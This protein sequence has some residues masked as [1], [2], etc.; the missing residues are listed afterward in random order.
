M[1]VLFLTN[2]YRVQ[3]T[4]GEDQSCQQ[5]VQGLT[6]RGHTTLVLTSMHGTGNVPVE[7]DGVYRSLFLEM[8]IVPW[9]HSIT[10]FTRRKAREQHNLQCFERVLEEFSPDVIFIWGMWNLPRSLAALAEAKYPDRVVYRFATYWP[11]LPSQHELYWRTPGRNWSSKL[12]KKLLCRIA[13]AMLSRENQRP[14]LSFKHAICVSATTRRKLVEAGIP[15]ANARIIHTG[16][17]HRRFLT[18]LQHRQLRDDHQTVNLLY[19]G[20]LVAEK[21]VDTAIQ[22]MKTLIADQAGRKIRLSLAGSG[23]ADYQS[24]LQRLVAQAGLGEY[25]S[26]LGH[27]PPED[28]PRL[29]Q[30]FDV[31]LV[32]SIWEEPFSRMVLEG[33]ISGLVVVATPTGGTI[34][35]LEDGENG[36]LF[37]PGDPED[38]A[39]KITLLV[40][41][42]HLRQKLGNAGRQTVIERF[43]VTRMMDEI[44]NFL[45]EVAYPPSDK[46]ERGPKVIEA[47]HTPPKVSVII[48]TYNH[49]EALRETLQSLAQQTYPSHCFEVIIVDDGSID[50]TQEIAAENFPFLLRYIQQNNQGDAAAR[51]VGA[52]QSQADVLVF[53]DDDI[54]VEPDYLTCLVQAQAV[55]KDRIVAGTWDLWRT[56]TNGQGVSAQILLESGAYYSRGASAEDKHNALNPTILAVEVPF[57]DIHSNNMA[58]R[59]ESYF[60]IGMMQSLEFSGSSMWCDLEFT[61]R[62]YRQ[63]YRFLRS[64]RAIC[65]H[66][67]RWAESLEDFKK[68]MREAAYRSV[69]LFQKHPELIFHVPMFYD[70]TPIKW[71]QDPPRLIA[72]KMARIVA[73]SRPALWSMERIVS[74]L[75]KYHPDSRVLP[76]LYRYVIGGS[77]FQGYRAG[78]GEFGQLSHQG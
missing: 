11:T 59:R 70:K 67:D 4:G 36:L 34:E 32:P 25:V 23:S 66:R 73:S 24:Y 42:P 48:P 20:R 64:T 10:F 71:R 38:L 14:K 54:L 69:R 62:A 65:W 26:F 29:L 16:I 9:R 37:T 13:L 31:L 30:K 56:K 41:D 78:L 49:K 43:T 76:V 68:R 45:K 61:Y 22:A 50:G 17:D 33:M 6:E 40:E 12:V 75:E 55:E 27:V 7:A 39:R 52:Q 18:D 57:S 1:R 28:M 51:N 35:I 2:F 5:V 53:L 21:G 60:E 44:E 3:E 58:I 74:G 77:I 46:V 19:A 63:G 72:R 47:M 8:D 15:V